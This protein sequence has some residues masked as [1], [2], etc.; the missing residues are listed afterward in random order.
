MFM[1]GGVYDNME[2]DSKAPKINFLWRI[3]N[4]FANSS[5]WRN[6]NY[7]WEIPS[8]E[9]T[10]PFVDDKVQTTRQRNVIQ[11]KI[12]YS[13]AWVERSEENNYVIAFHDA[14]PDETK[15]QFL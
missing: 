13:C 11:G 1:I 6:P 5:L 12:S 7:L 9:G 8:T 3:F 14:I 10:Y 15:I 4:W 2:V